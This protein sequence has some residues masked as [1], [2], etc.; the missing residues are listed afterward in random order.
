MD[1]KQRQLATLI[2]HEPQLD[3]GVSG[4]QREGM[5]ERIN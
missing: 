3:L 5:A 1:R 2:D 4:Q